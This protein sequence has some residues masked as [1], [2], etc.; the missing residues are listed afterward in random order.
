V[1]GYVE[2][3]DRRTDTVIAAVSDSVTA[4]GIPAAGKM[5]AAVTLS[6]TAAMHTKMNMHVLEGI[7]ARTGADHPSPLN[8]GNRR[9][10]GV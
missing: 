5:P 7:A 6:L 8:P 9:P 2:I 4:A 1:A 3:R 10:H